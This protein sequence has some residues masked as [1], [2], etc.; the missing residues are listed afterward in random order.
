MTAPYSGEMRDGQRK[1]SYGVV[2]LVP[3]NRMQVVIAEGKRFRRNVAALSEK[4]RI[5]K[6]RYRVR[7][8]KGKRKSGRPDGIAFRK[9][10]VIKG[11]ARRAGKYRVEAR[12]RYRDLDGRMRWTRKA[13]LLF[14]VVPRPRVKPGVF[15]S[16]LPES[17]R[18]KAPSVPA[19]VT[20]G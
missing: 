1:R 9:S 3:G 16:M 4:P 14:Q 15:D 5:Q 19:K 2:S 13:E 20:F 12:G 7:K 18:Q 6:V 8:G 11:V 10:G 17:M